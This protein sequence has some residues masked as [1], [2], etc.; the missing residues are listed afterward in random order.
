LN[1]DIST[2]KNELNKNGWYSFRST[3]YADNI[4]I[5][6][7]QIGIPFSQH[8][9]PSIQTLRPLTQELARPNSTSSIYGLNSF[10]P[11]T[12]MAHWPTPPKYVIMRAKIPCSRIPTILFDSQ[13]LNL[14]QN[15]LSLWERS[16]WQISKIK[17][18]FLCSIFFY[19][20]DNKGI[21]WDPCTMSAYGKIANEIKSEI[22][23]TLNE[24]FDRQSIDFSWD[25]SEDILIFNNWRM[26]HSRPKVSLD[27]S[28]RELERIFLRGI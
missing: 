13:R 9:M 22:E 24:Q 21:R 6:A 12:D 14:K 3:E 11:H 27:S 5:L 15:V 16:V 10:P 20:M 8:E 23:M 28:S 1:I 18:P 19:H 17:Q 7:K 2:I 4:Q 25:S 26:L